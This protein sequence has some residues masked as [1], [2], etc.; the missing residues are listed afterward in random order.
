MNCIEN[1]HPFNYAL[2]ARREYI[3]MFVSP[4]NYGDHRSVVHE[5]IDLG[6]DKFI[7]SRTPVL[8]VN[9]LDALL[10]AGFTNVEN[11][12]D[13][14]KIDTQGADFEFLRACIPLIKEN[15]KV[16]IEFSPYHLFANG[17]SKNEVSDIVSEFSQI[18]KIVP[19]ENQHYL[20]KISL[21]AVE[22]FYE[23]QCN[24]YGGYFDLLLT[25]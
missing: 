9:P 2:G 18:Q 7:V 23:A 1:V 25:L 22:Q 3:R 8:K 21:N 16:A 20:E 19:S 12:F 6:E 14:M 11:S 4:D 15:G 5:K 24:S 17:T 13:L 10:E